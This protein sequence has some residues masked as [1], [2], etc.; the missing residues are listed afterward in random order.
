MKKTKENT[1]GR[2]SRVSRLSDNRYL[3]KVTTAVV[4]WEMELGNQQS[5]IIMRTLPPISIY[6]CVGGIQI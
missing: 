3:A 6:G 1:E 2:Y 5:E 4:H